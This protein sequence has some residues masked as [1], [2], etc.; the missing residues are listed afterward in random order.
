MIGM[1]T[2]LSSMFDRS[3]NVFD[4]FEDAELVLVQRESDMV[5][6]RDLLAKQVPFMV[7]FKWED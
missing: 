2:R 6:V 4:A 1:F 5:K 3:L 7:V